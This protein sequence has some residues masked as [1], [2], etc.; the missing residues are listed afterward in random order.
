M[1]VRL[2]VFESPHKIRR[3]PFALYD[4][5]LNEPPEIHPEWANRRIPFVL[6]SVELRERCAS[7]LRGARFESYSF[8]AN[9]RTS[10]D[11]CEIWT[12]DAW[13]RQAIRNALAREADPNATPGTSS[14]FRIRFHDPNPEPCYACE[15]GD[16][17]IPGDGEWLGHWVHA[18][19][20]TDPDN[21]YYF[22]VDDRWIDESAPRP[23]R[24]RLRSVR[25]D[26]S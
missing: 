11:R 9:G 10:C 2:F 22:C 8:D 13:Q 18:T 3:V 4:R 1:G 5:L 19:G 17:P 12:P 25:R 21:P 14:P 24:P 16:P 20:D 6:A 7:R 23:P 15:A 26:D